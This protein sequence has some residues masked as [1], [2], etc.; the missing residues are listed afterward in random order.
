MGQRDELA[1]IHLCMT[2]DN[3]SVR[4]DYEVFHC[5]TA[6]MRTQLWFNSGPGRKHTEIITDGTRNR[7]TEKELVWEMS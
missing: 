5:K 6:D 2:S 4:R 7:L 3:L 1:S